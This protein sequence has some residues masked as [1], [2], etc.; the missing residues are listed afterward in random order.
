MNAKDSR[1]RAAV[2]EE[3]IVDAQTEVKQQ[4]VSISTEEIAFLLALV[5]IAEAVRQ[6]TDQLRELSEIIK[7]K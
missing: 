1:A 5:D 6:N 2:V 3:L 4:V 7:H